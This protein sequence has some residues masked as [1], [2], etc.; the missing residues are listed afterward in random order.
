MHVN[1]YKVKTSKGNTNG[2]SRRGTGGPIFFDGGRAGWNSQRR[3]W[4]LSSLCLWFTLCLFGQ[5]GE[6]AA[7]PQELSV[8]AGET[9]EVT[10]WVH[11]G[12]EPVAAIDFILW[13]DKDA[14]EPLDIIKVSS[15]LN[16]NQIKPFIDK[17][18]GRIVYAS[19]KLD[20]PWPTEP[21]PL[22]AIRAKALD[23]A[24]PTA[25]YHEPEVVPA[26]S[27]AFEG[28]NTMGRANALQVY[29][30]PKETQATAAASALRSLPD[31]TF[32]EESG[33]YH[34]DY[35]AEDAGKTLISASHQE[36]AVPD[37]VFE[38]RVSRGEEYK[39]VLNP[40]AMPPGTYTLGMRSASGAMVEREVRF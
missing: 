35:T 25:L 38:T 17:E 28:R 2:I 40:G 6:I 21:F 30:L 39:Y 23:M 18:Q 33:C 22:V 4:M 27:M 8:H 12:E 19:F 37:F 10:W 3:R 5:K 16:V 7:F 32:D 36:G 9:F 31:I 26:T 24:G 14:I 20:H 15:P 1:R 11:P 29:I 13:Y 34:F